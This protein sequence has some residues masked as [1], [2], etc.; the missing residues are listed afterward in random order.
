MSHD[1]RAAHLRKMDALD[2]RGLSAFATIPIGG[3][4]GEE[5][6]VTT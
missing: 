5:D 4:G 2:S 6:W 1:H 3:D